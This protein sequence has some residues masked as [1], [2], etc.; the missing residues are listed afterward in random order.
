M[1]NRTPDGHGGAGLDLAR[2]ADCAIAHDREGVTSAGLPLARMRDDA[3]ERLRAV[4]TGHAAIA[5][6]TGPTA[7]L[8][9]RRLS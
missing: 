3:Y 5:L 8:A 2:T 9:T 4:F 1:M 6:A 7:F